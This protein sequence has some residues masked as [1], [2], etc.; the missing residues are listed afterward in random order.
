MKHVPQF[1]KVLIDV[2]LGAEHAGLPSLERIDTVEHLGHCCVQSDSWWTAHLTV[3]EFVWWQWLEG[4]HALCAHKHRLVGGW[5]SRK[6]YGS[7]EE[8]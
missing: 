6:K 3:F 4:D 8:R 7:E 1:Q 5:E 2:L